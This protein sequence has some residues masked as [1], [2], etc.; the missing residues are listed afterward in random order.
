LFN[1]AEILFVQTCSMLLRRGDAVF[2]FAILRKRYLVKCY[3][4]MV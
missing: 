2:V 3:V 4:C 1:C